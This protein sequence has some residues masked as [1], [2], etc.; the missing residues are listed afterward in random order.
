L[1]ADFSPVFRKTPSM[2]EA[3]EIFF[4]MIDSG[5]YIPSTKG[6]NGTNPRLFRIVFSIPEDYLNEAMKRL[7]RF[8]AEHRNV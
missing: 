3:A 6:F 1:W 7:R 8:V 5:I 4:K 2:D